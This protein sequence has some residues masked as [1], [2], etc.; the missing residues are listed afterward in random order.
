MANK[1]MYAMIATVAMIGRSRLGLDVI[2]HLRIMDGAQGDCPEP[3]IAEVA[4]GGP[5]QFN[6]WTSGGTL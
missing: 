3:S 4:K 5:V 1:A 2:L 6:L